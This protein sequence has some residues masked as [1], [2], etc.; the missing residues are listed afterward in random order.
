MKTQALVLAVLTILPSLA[1]ADCVGGGRAHGQD[2]DTLGSTACGDHVLVSPLHLHTYITGRKRVQ[3][4]TQCL[5]EVRQESQPEEGRSVAGRGRHPSSSSSCSGP[6]CLE[7]DAE[8]PRHESVLL[9]MQ[10]CG[11]VE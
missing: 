1:L 8:L 2:C 11:L 6:I 7:A 9:Q 4:L 5:V 3:Q 10:V